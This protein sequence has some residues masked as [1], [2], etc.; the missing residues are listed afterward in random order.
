MKPGY[1]SWEYAPEKGERCDILVPPAADAT[2]LL[3][4]NPWIQPIQ[5]LAWADE[6]GL[7]E[8]LGQATPVTLAELE[9]H[10]GLNE[11]G[12]DGFLGIFLAMKLARRIN[13][14][15]YQLLPVAREYLLRDSPYYLGYSLFRGIRRRGIP[16]RMRH[17]VTLLERLLTQAFAR[18]CADV[19]THWFRP[20]AYGRLRRLREQHSRN[21]AAAVVAAQ[22]SAFD[23]VRH[24][25]D[26]AGG[27]GTF[28]IPF[29]QR[30]P[31]TK[32]SLIELPRSVP[33][34]RRFLNAHGVGARVQVLGMDAIHEP[35]LPA[36]DSVF[37]GNLIHD[38]G[39][40]DCFRLL[41][42]CRLALAEG[43]SVWLHER[44]WNEN[45]DG[46]LLTAQWNFIMMTHSRD[47]KQRTASEIHRLLKEAQFI[48]GAVVPTAAGFTMVEGRVVA[49]TQPHMVVDTLA[50]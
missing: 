49:P 1:Q 47:G 4:L 30:C 11:R 31:A 37:I 42:A 33:H 17:P 29:A 9:R 8:C 50:L 6:L 38:L 32:V 27:S 44:L 24:L 46:P 40:A 43:G 34:T 39:D 21:L 41:S 36:G 5:C 20:L 23:H 14:D 48:P 13:G 15:A 12:L 10:T 18:R 16:L 35:R 28:A 22:H 19:A 2:D 45:K 3:S 26:I 25:I 7:F